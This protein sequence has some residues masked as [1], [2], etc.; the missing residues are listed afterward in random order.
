MSQGSLSLL[1]GRV[2]TG[3]V[4]ADLSATKPGQAAHLAPLT[5]LVCRYPAYPHYAG[6]GDPS[7]AASFGGVRPR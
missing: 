2:E 3:T 1:I 7:D 4:P 6:D 5:R